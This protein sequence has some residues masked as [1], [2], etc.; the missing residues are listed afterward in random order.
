MST[1][2]TRPSFVKRMM[3]IAIMAALICVCSWLTVPSIVPFTM[4]TFAV[5]CALLLLGGKDGLYATLLYLMMGAVGLPVFSGFRG[6]VGYM[7]GPTGGYMVGFL[8]TALLFWL[9]EPI[10]KSHPEKKALRLCRFPVLVAGLLLCY[11]AGTVWFITVMSA[12]GTDY[13][14]VAALGLCVFPF[15][16]PDAVKLV[17]AVVLSDA[18]NKRLRY[19]A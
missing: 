16:L 14:F 11:T 13:D 19:N 2:T 3:T 15:L 7:L 17:L 8:L 6:G 12:N 10:W 18:V 9:C 4:Q 1:E 5:F